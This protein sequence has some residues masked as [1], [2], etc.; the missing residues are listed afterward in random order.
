MGLPCAQA[1]E[2]IIV[3]DSGRVAEVGT[4]QELVRR[5]GRY[6]QLVST[7]SLSLSNS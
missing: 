4:H 3:L 5:G 7:Q 6:A 1:A 2:Q